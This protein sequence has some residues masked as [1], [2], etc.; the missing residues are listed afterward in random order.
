ML[1]IK[2]S[3]RGAGTGHNL[4]QFLGNEM[5]TIDGCR[6]FIN[7]PIDEADVWFVS[8]DLEDS[9]QTCRVPPGQKIFISAETSWEPGRYVPGTP[10][11]DFISQFDEI[12]SCH[13]IYMDNVVSEPPFLPWMINANHGSTLLAPHLR[14]VNYF[15]KLKEVEKTKAISVFCSNQTLTAEHRMRLRFVE[16]IKAH[17]GDRLDW[18]GNGINSLPA[19]WEG[20]APYRYTIVLENQSSANIFTEKIYDAYLAMSYPIYWGAPNL[21]EYFQESG[22][23][24]INIRDLHGSI[25]ILEEILQSDL[26]ERSQAALLENKSRVINGLNLFKRLA[27]IANERSG[28]QQEASESSEVYPIGHFTQLGKQKTAKKFVGAGFTRIG[29]RLSGDK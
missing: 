29:N 12:R 20:L 1:R 23:R 24:K 25:Q 21:G 7:E 15:D 3:V 27:A 8:E 19:K 9:D 6:F 4:S 22:F 13:D 17:F 14:D 16:Q 18:F 26:A 11:W 10:Q 2:L 5:N 28:K